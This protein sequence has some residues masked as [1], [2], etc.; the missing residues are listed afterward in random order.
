VPKTITVVRHAETNANS[1]RRWQGTTDSGISPVGKGQ[2]DRLAVRFRDR[3]PGLFVASDLARTQE[4]AAVI[5]DARPDPSWREFS[6][7]RWEGL[8]SDDVME[9]YPAEYRA[10][11]SG[12]DVQPGGGDRMSD[13]RIRILAA[14]DRLVDETP[15]DGHAT[16][17]THG[18]AIWALLSSILEIGRG[19]AMIPSHNTA[20]TEIVDFGDGRR[21]IKVFNDASH[22][23]ST[24]TQFGPEG[25]L[26]MFIRHG[27]SEGNIA[28]RWD[29]T[30]DSALTPHGEE[31]ASA[32]AMVAP[33]PSTMFASPQTRA[34]TTARIIGT[35]HGVVPI[36]DDRL[37]EMAF[38]GWDGLTTEQIKAQFPEDFEAYGRGETDD[39]VASSGGESLGAVGERMRSTLTDMSAN[40]HG[41]PIV[42]VSHGAAI[43]ALMLNVL[44]LTNVGRRFIIVPRNTSMSS[45]VVSD[46]NPVVASYN[47]A[48]HLER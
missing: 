27:E 29:G 38:G 18:G 44:G 23:E 36:V 22:L 28:G 26:V 15:D 8:T 4:T 11:I 30:V 21:V 40:G 7:G 39:P 20:L 13:F 9:R 47:V 19:A 34:A 6:I 37:R 12:E 3:D 24:T 25:D 5:G 48:P 32:A 10:F 33:R 42:A 43:R 2:L 41:S 17:V 31:Q 16:V 35:H 45:I 46:G 1:E 14:F